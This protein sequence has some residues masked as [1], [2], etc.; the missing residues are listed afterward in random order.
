MVVIATEKKTV[1]LTILLSNSTF[2]M[3]TFSKSY[4]MTNGNFTIELKPSNIFDQFKS[5]KSIRFS[6]SPQQHSLQRSCIKIVTIS[7]FYLPQ[8]W[9]I[10]HPPEWLQGQTFYIVSISFLTWM[11]FSFDRKS[12]FCHWQKF[13]RGKDKTFRDLWPEI[14][15]KISK[16]SSSKEWY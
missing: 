2:F 12:K 16:V 11:L 15:I 10:S 4:T 5:I 14:I 8:N 13:I 7:W 9:R 6:H 1:K 3:V